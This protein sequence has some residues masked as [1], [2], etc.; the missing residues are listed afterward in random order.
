MIF[1]AVLTE[2]RILWEL[3]LIIIINPHLVL[4]WFHSFLSGIGWGCLSALAF[5]YLEKAIVILLSW[6][7]EPPPTPTV[8]PIRILLSPRSPNSIPT[9]RKRE[10]WIVMRNLP[11]IHIRKRRRWGTFWRS[12]TTELWN[13][14][15]QREINAI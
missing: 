4:L 6:S 10:L 9:I 5:Q 13:E 3:K 11:L 14:W 2:R 1:N 8:A 15:K 7:Q 12:T